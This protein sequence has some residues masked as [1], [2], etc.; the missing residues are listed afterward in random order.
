VSEDLPD[1]WVA[2]PLARVGTLQNGPFGSL[3][4]RSDY[5]QGGTPLINP[6][7][8]VAGRLVP[9]TEIT[10]GRDVMVR[11]SS[12][13]MKPGDVVIG[14][15]GEMGRAALVGDERDDWFCGTGCAFVRP[16]EVCL[17]RFLASWFG[18]PGVRSRLEN[19]A[20][21]ATMSNLSTRILGNLDVPLPPLPEQRRIIDKIEALLEQVNQAKARLDRVPLILKRFRQ[22]VLAA[23]CSGELTQDWRQ[24]N[25]G[26]GDVPHAVGQVEGPF[27]LPVGWR[28]ELLG[29][30]GRFINGDRSKNYPSKQHRVASGIPFI[31]AG[32]LVDGVVDLKDMDFITQERFALLTS[33]KV[34]V[35]DV[36]YCLRGSLGKAAIVRGIDQGAIA[37]SLLIL[38]L[39]HRLC[40]EAYAFHYLTSPLGQE[41][42]KLY[43]NGSAQPNLSAA[44]VAR[45]VVPMPPTDEQSEIVRQ[46]GELF[47]LASSIERR[48]Q[49]ATGRAAKLPQSIL[50]K[51]FAG[52][53]VP[54]E[55]ELARAEGRSYETAAELLKRVTVSS[56]ETRSREGARPARRRKA[57]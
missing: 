31:N 17:G 57:G 5:V 4:H 2:L 15:R 30:L 53:L 26:R 35:G 54:T 16:S 56:A 21:G 33:G 52:E 46:V 25:P 43:D 18:S 23:A 24:T 37:S 1:G 49:D 48:V 22:S 40:S 42:I 11:L 50:S 39:N 27:E 20:V 9:D 13:V 44:D 38:R 32:H 55:A 36:L 12:Y 29:S 19:D 47:A 51:A 41:M 14:R 3:L 7:N 8:I 34:E 28:W 6:A 10:V 45:F